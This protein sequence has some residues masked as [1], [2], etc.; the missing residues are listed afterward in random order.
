[1]IKKIWICLLAFVLASCSITP[2]NP[3]LIEG[4]AEGK[5]GPIKVELFIKD[6]T[7]KHIELIEHQETVGFD[8]T[9]ISIISQVLSSQSL[10]VD[11]VSGATESSI[12]VLNAIKDA[13]DKTDITLSNRLP[14]T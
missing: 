2:N 11:V 1:M 9:M 13:L 4:S 14:G 6:N 12:G 5:N 8:K 3:S 7:I 10:D